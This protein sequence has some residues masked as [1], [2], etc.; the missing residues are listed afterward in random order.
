MTDA[1]IAHQ[2]AIGGFELAKGSKPR[3]LGIVLE[4]K[5]AS[6]GVSSV[7]VDGEG[8]T[9][10][11]AGTAATA[12]CS[13]GAGSVTFAAAT[14]GVVTGTWIIGKNHA[15]GTDDLDI[16][17]A[18]GEFVSQLATNGVGSVF[19][20]LKT[21]SDIS[22]ATEAAPAVYTT[23]TPHGFIVNDVVDVTGASNALHNGRHVITAVGDTTHFSTGTVG[24]GGA[25]TTAAATHVIMPGTCNITSI[26]GGT[27]SFLLCNPHEDTDDLSTGESYR[28]TLRA[29]ARGGV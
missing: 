11:V 2:A 6:S 28:L 8:S 13:F 7:F 17:M 9:P 14:G 24:S 16:F 5:F 20:P 21:V 1:G 27:V 15:A 26:N 23:L 12:V 25:S 29:Y 10:V 3:A 4:G 22:A 18:D 19:S